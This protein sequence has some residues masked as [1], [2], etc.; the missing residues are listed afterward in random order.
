MQTRSRERTGAGGSFEWGAL[1]AEIRNAAATTSRCVGS[2]KVARR[3]CDRPA[4]IPTP[5]LFRAPKEYVSVLRA[6]SG[7]QGIRE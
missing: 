3:S 7:T 1:K 6:E 5:L 4:I 2:D